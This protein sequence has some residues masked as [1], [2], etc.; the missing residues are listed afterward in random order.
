MQSGSSCHRN[1][2]RSY[3]KIVNIGPGMSPTLLENLVSPLSPKRNSYNGFT[4]NRPGQKVRNAFGIISGFPG[5]R[6]F[7]MCVTGRS[8]C[9]PQK[10]QSPRGNINAF[11]ESTLLNPNMVLQAFW[12]S[13]GPLLAVLGDLPM[14]S[15]MAIGFTVYST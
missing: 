1:C 4:G 11:D 13:L 10:H 6:D 5:N 14:A 9:V 12:G 15:L 7:D 3:V 2:R 8:Q